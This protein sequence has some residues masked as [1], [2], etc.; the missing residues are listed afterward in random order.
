[1]QTLTKFEEASLK[2][3]EGKEILSAAEPRPPDK[4][5]LKQPTEQRKFGF[6]E[7]A[8]NQF[9]KKFLEETWEVQWLAAV[10]VL[11]LY[12]KDSSTHGMPLEGKDTTTLFF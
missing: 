7:N 8:E 9:E 1:V 6:A 3:N 2:D 12:L 4:G 5:V 10:I 11:F